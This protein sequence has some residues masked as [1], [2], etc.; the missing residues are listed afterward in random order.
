MEYIDKHKEIYAKRAHRMIDDYIASQWNSDVNKYINIDYRDIK[1]ELAT[2]LTEEQ[3]GYCCYCMRTLKEGGQTT[4][5][6]VIPKGLKD[7]KEYDKYI[8]TG[9]F[10]ENMM[11]FTSIKNISTPICC[12]PYPHH[13]AYEN[14]V[15]SC[16]GELTNIQGERVVILPQSC[17]NNK[18]GEEY[19]YPFFFRKDIASLLTYEADGSLSYEDD[20]WETMLGKSVLNLLN[21]TLQMIRKTWNVIASEYSIAEVD[22]AKEDKELRSEILANRNLTKEE[23]QTLLNTTYWNLLTEYSWFYHY[24]KEKQSRKIS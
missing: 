1:K 5:E 8:A 18:R 10:C 20:S 2:I 9:L 16:N 3:K 11:Q 7:Q 17:C 4:L 13:L 22:Q 6:H 19:I 21:K 24:Y 23:R 15:A 14:L 12:P